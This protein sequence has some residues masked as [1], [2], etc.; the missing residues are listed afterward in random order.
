[1][2]DENN[3]PI[4]AGATAPEGV[5]EPKPEEAP[6]TPYE[7]LVSFMESRDLKTPTDVSDFVENLGQ[8]EQWKKQYGDSQ[9][10]V[11]ELR[12]QMEQMQ[13][14]V[15]QQ[16]IDPGYEPQVN[17]GDVVEERIMKV[18]GNMQQQNQQQQMKYLGERN[19]LMKR[20]GWK[21]V[22]PHF[23]RWMQ[24]PSVQFEIQKGTLTQEKVFN[25][26]N[27]HYMMSK[28]NTFVKQ[29]PEGAV[30]PAAPNAEKSDRNQEPTPETQ[31]RSQRMGKAIEEQNVDALLKDLIPD[32]DPI[33]KF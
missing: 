15:Q 5:E 30:A 8:T 3:A 27:D 12:R 21:E 7:E 11:G 22:Q 33:V 16:S 13:L 18:L 6:A 29:I 4:E 23:D 32:E 17:L 25:R 2:A 19:E 26:L 1:M 24:D 9:N 28:I 14:Q 31:A 20:P 10:Q